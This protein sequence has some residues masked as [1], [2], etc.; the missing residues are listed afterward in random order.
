[1]IVGLVISI[2]SVQKNSADTPVIWEPWNNIISSPSCSVEQIVTLALVRTKGTSCYTGNCMQQPQIW[3]MLLVY[4][5][6]LWCE[7]V[8]T[9]GRELDCSL[10][11][12]SS[13]CSMEPC[14][15]RIY[16]IWTL[17]ISHHIWEPGQTPTYSTDDGQWVLWSIL[18]VPV[19]QW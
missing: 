14:W 10:A 5:W 19:A 1:M 18:E 7:C 8:N 15:Q 17:S 13:D 4:C 12:P 2:C 11:V 16:H 6:V 3:S 9:Y